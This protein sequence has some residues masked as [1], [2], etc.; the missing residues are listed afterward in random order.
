MTDVVGYPAEFADRYRREGLWQERTIPAAL[1]ETA[2]SH[3]DAPA[4]VTTAGS[5]TY[6]ELT[7]TVDN[8]A[9]GLVAAGLRPGD[10]VILQMGN[11]AHAVAAL[12]AIMRAGALPVCTLA[13]HR[14]HEIG[15][16]AEKTRAVAHVVQA[17]LPGFDLVAFAGEIAAE[18]PSM[19]L[20]LTL[21][22]GSDGVAIE[23]LAAREPS[24]AELERLAEIERETDL[25]APA[26]LQL[27]G[28]TTGTPKV[29]PRL[30]PEYW[31]NG[32]AIADWWSLTAADRCAFALPIVH[33]AGMANALFAAHGVGAALLLSTPRPDELL[34]LMAGH[35]ATYTLLSPGLAAAFL[36]DERFDGAFAHIRTLVLSAAPVPRDVFD[37]LEARG[38][39]TTQAF[40][41][42]EGM[43]MFT[44]ADAPADVRAASVGVPISP[45]D[46]VR[47]LE[48]GTETPVAEGEVG[49]LCA[50]GPYTI[51]GYL[52]E[53]ERNGEAF[54]SDGFY[55]SGDLAACVRIAG[56]ATYVLRGRSKDLINRG[57]EKINAEE[58][59]TLLAGHPA[60]QE[61]ALVAM[62]DPRLGERACVFV[63]T[64]PG[65]QPPTLPELCTYLEARG[66]AKYK[67][68]ERLEH[69]TALPRTN[70]G[71][72]LK[73]DLRAAITADL[74]T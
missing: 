44:P 49:E 3:P 67:W 10:P 66:V 50:R 6:A 1:R 70:V 38:V 22:G 12:Y 58:V 42:T 32:A 2:R 56:Q 64:R 21:G 19:R 40:G 71:K 59:E 25:S 60:V 15:A 14:R 34:G 17:D 62:P 65:A 41:M 8:I 74:S 29:I 35:G 39:H 47:L 46:E 45:F 53:P 11:T 52:G 23:E 33:N 26:V 73:R 68:P 57:G 18:I 61:T 13:L 48:P 20:L 28:G 63:V 55:R 4:L 37:A 72:V 31:Y 36:A 24:A 54:T 7:A 16:I 30:H 69:L 27:S 5:W 51:R 43:F 9:A